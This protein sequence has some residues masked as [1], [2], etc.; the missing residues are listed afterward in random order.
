MQPI[1]RVDQILLQ[2]RKQLADRAQRGSQAVGRSANRSAQ[3]RT[4][5]APLAE[6]LSRRVSELRL[7]G[8]SDQRLLTR[9]LIEQVLL[10]ELG[11]DLTN[12]A[13]FQR[14]VDD[15]QRTIEDD[16]A[17]SELVASLSR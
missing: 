14:V 17:F 7:A 10:A 11:S 2:L 15:V 16:A 3:G 6:S 5:E 4:D 8:L 12:D 13:N 1:T 9:V